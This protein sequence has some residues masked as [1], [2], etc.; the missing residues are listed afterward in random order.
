MKKHTLQPRTGKLCTQEDFPG[1][2]ENFNFSDAI[3]I[4]NVQR[5]V[6]NPGID[7]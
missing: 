3:G 5:V 1:K 2:V 7:L 6:V 4:F